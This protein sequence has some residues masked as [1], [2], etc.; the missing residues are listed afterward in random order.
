[1]PKERLELAKYSIRL[2][3]ADV[4]TLIT[5]F[6]TIGY[7]DIVRRLVH[8]YAEQLRQESKNVTRR[9]AGGIGEESQ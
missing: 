9:S 2:I 7:N 1:M 5:Y 6:P 8:R 4:D 3:K